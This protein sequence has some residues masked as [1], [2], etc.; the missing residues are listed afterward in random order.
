VA[1]PRNRR[2]IEVNEFPEE[3][4]H[5]LIIPTSHSQQTSFIGPFRGTISALSY[6]C[7]IT[8]TI[9][10]VIK[11]ILD[12]VLALAYKLAS[13]AGPIRSPIRSALPC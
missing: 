7:T 13:M 2:V 4:P 12:I 9:F 3:S 1:T 5:S 8:A 11:L 6:S 10:Y